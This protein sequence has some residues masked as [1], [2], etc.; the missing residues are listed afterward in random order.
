MNRL[1]RDASGHRYGAFQFSRGI[2]LLASVC[3]AWLILLIAARC[4]EWTA[5]AAAGGL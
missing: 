1:A 5:L 2:W 3:G 4:L